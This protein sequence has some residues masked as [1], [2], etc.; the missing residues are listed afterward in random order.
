MKDNWFCTQTADHGLAAISS[1][2]EFSA[3]FTHHSSMYVS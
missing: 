1:K 2:M 3:L